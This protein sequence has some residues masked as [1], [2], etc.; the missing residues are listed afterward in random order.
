MPKKITYNEFYQQDQFKNSNG[1]IDWGKAATAWIEY[2]ENNQLSIINN[3]NNPKI[4]SPSD[5]PAFNLANELCDE[6]WEIVIKWDFFAKKTL[7]DQWVRATDSIAANITE[8]FGR[9]FFGE[10]KVFLYYARG[11]LYEA[12]FWME[13][14]H[15]RGLINN[16][17]YDNLKERFDQLP[18]ELNK[19]IKI[20]KSQSEEW[21]GRK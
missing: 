8:G 3:Q 16:Q 19:L 6:V 21:K 13:K 17:L 2:E 4:K 1:S 10:Y 5:L 18:L 20:V 15:K 14:A 12:V 11:S 7:S 9:Y